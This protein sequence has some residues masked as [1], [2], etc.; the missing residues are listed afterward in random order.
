[1]TFHFT[2]QRP[3]SHRR[4]SYS[5]R[6]SVVALLCA[7]FLFSG[8]K[9]PT[10]SK[11]SPVS[12][13]QVDQAKQAKPTKKAEA[14]KSE[15]AKPEDKGMRVPI[16]PQFLIAPGKGVSAIRFGTNLENLQKHMAAPCDILTETR[17]VYVNQ[18][19]EFGLSEGVVSA[20]KFHRRDRLVA[21]AKPGAERYYGS[22][23]G[24][25]RPNIM[26]GLLRDIVVG[27]V[28][29]PLKKE[30]LLGQNGEVERHSYDGV[31]FEY[32][33]IENGN[34]VLSGIEVVKSA[35]A[36]QLKALPAPATPANPIKPAAVPTQA[37][38]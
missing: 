11:P 18:A 12:T 15:L 35:T 31:I 30:P 14:A 7:A 2:H 10:A 16:G 17:C 8:C 24:G 13:K 21:G 5:A 4:A 28:G 38:P 22:F 33:K 26:F 6:T 20:M 36:T 27:E 3:Q 19:A 23:N 32:D 29:E 1:M 25:M 37:A 9:K 34:I